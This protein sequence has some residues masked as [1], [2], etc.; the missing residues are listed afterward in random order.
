M[1][2]RAASG[3][4]AAGIAEGKK[5]VKTFDD[6]PGPSLL[7]NLY[8]LF[9]RGYLL[10]SHELQDIFKKKYGP[11]W[12]STVGLY[13]AVNVADVDLLETLLRQEGKYPMRVDMQV[14]KLHRDLRDLAYGPLTEEGHRW[15]TL[16][17]VLNK[18]MLK[19]AEAV[20]Y[21]GAINEVV[22]DFLRSLD[23]I[24]GETP[25]G[26][27]VND[28]ANVFY[29]FAFEG[30]F[31][32]LFET[33]IGCLEKKIPPES[34]KFIDS[35]GAM[36]KYSV[37]VTMLPAWTQNL[38]PY[39][40]LYL[41]NYN[42]F[43]SYNFSFF[44]FWLSS[45]SPLLSLLLYFCSLLS[46]H[47][48]SLLHSLLALAFFSLS[49]RSCYRSLLSLSLFSLLP[50]FSSHSCSL[51]LLAL[52]LVLFLLLLLP[53]ILLSSRSLLTLFSFLLLLSSRSLLALA[54]FSLSSRSPL[55]LF[56]LLPSFSSRS[57]PPSLLA[58]ALLL[59]SLLPS[60]SSRSCPPSLLALALLLF[61]LLPSFS[62]CSCPPSRLA[63]ALLLVSLLPSFSSRS[64][65]RSRL[66]LALVLVS[67]LPR[68]RLALALV[69]FSLLP[70]FSSRSCPRSLLA[71]ALVLFSLLPSFSSRSLLALAPVLFSLL[72]S[73]SSRSCP[74]SL[75]T[76]ALFSLLLSSHSLLALSLFALALLSLSSRSCPRSLLALA[77]LLFSLLPSFP[78]H[79]CSLLTLFSLSLFSL[80][81]SSH[82]LLAL[83]LVLFL[84]LPSFSSRS[85]PRSFYA[86]ALVLFS[87]LPSFFFRS[88][89]RSLLALVLV[90]FSL[91]LSSR[92]LLALV[93][94]SLSLFLLL[95][96]SHSLLAL[97][98]FALALVLF[99]LLPSFSFRSCPRSL[100]A[101][102]LVLFSLLPSFSSRSCPRR[103]LIDQKM[104]KIQARLDRGEEVQ[105]EYLT[106]LLSS[107]KL[108]N[109]E[110]NGS[111]AELLLAGVDTTS[112][113][114]SWALYHLA[115]D[116]QTQQAL[117]QEVTNII[118]G[119]R[120]PNAEDIARMPLL[121]AVIRETLRLYPVIPINSR[122]AVEKDITLGGYWF[123]KDTLFGLNH[124]Q[125]SRDEENFP[126]AEKFLPQRWLRDLRVKNNPFSSIPFGFGVRACVGRRIAELEM[127]LALSRMIRKYEIRPDPRGVEVSAMTR[128]V[129]TPSQP[130]NLRFLDRKSADKTDR[131]RPGTMLCR[132][133]GVLR[134]SLRPSPCQLGG[135]RRAASPGV[136]GPQA[137]HRSGL[138]TIN[139]LPGPS[140]LELIYWVFLRG[141]LFHMHDLEV[142][143]KKKYGPIWVSTLSHYRMVNIA[144]PAILETL[145][146]Q[147]GK[148]PTRASMILWKG[149]RDLRGHSYGPLT[150]QGHRWQTLRAVLN[151]KMLKPT[152]AARHTDT[153][154]QVVPELL[155]KIRE[156]RAES[157]SGPVV[158]NVAELMYKFA[159]ESIC[160]VIFEARLGCLR[161]PV[162]EDTQKFISSV[163]IMLENEVVI[164]RLPPWTRNWLP[165]WR[166]FLEAWDAIFDY[167][168]KLIDRKMEDIE[169]RLRRGEDLG[170][171][172]LTH[173]LTNGTLSLR[174]VYG[175]MPE[176]L[177]A[178][179]DT[180][181]NTLTWALYL[182]AKNPDVQRTVYE[183]VVSVI[184]G[185]KVPTPEDL[186]RMPLLK[187]VIK[188]TL[189]LYPVVPQNGRIITDKEVILEGYVFPKDTL[190][191]LS[192]YVLSRDEESFSEAERFLPRRW[193][194]GSGRTHHP[195]SSI[196]FG[197]GVRACLGRRVA[198]LEM[199]LALSQMI[200]EFR[201]LPDPGMKE[202][203]TKN[204]V[205][206]VSDV[207]INLQFI[208][209][210]S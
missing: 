18:K 179:V 182:L 137:E 11:I 108:T 105:G 134:P 80:L 119:D 10:Y 35:I 166:R 176:I 207:P 200:R 127:H 79:S 115:R 172:Y 125:I 44:L 107:G 47:S 171:A 32:H 41:E 2:C 138:K 98:L 82:S 186:S 29:R 64:C 101:L 209:R 73:F 206:L 50:S 151:Q 68:S 55:T 95:L 93:L 177:Q 160:G 63:L 205:V 204:R 16:R 20:L 96:S 12:K 99:S 122:V 94:F 65:P 42:I 59:F 27:M 144:G 86:L 58:L 178:G 92:S 51:S 170:D 120:I 62:S 143:L 145:L 165:Y 89:P 3:A 113:T 158:K 21:T 26:V 129:L 34:Q 106:Y 103:K 33:R 8:W 195:F 173:L 53:L 130:I 91:L 72:P 102:V 87:L 74:R 153:L 183:E 104:E 76:L 156:L 168:K 167:G 152:E 150:E 147:E 67:L 202:V 191:V 117:Y 70:S 199:H 100:L 31:I 159:F 52:A 174:E 175:I 201:V 24:R 203:K 6:L 118:P 43:N 128:I 54:L 83:A 112:N 7:T 88:C 149:H 136:S 187:A 17:T 45:P 49:S 141:Y 85:C 61:S 140:Q 181:S 163:G 148:Y 46:F 162:A 133:S 25:S 84:L 81:L 19:P 155:D 192:H 97:S 157:Q 78:S 164:E 111:V 75:L 56:S 132:L 154:N 30:I 38:L 9:L 197:Y 36:L 196:P 139:D 15:H 114:L 121:K 188:E 146:K 39:Y 190:F 161:G 109:K 4:A 131:K 198:E 142:Q 22:T 71:L 123:P 57:C 126:E 28:I 116:P 90:L 77:L 13:N 194:R 66:A 23:V 110:V 69:L 210:Q 208:D 135:T 169:G 189:R 14:W 48:P 1:Q 37:Y 60:F 180:T 5:K 124:Y 184:P 185:D 40:R 193:L